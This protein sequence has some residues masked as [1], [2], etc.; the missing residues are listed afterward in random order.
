MKLNNYSYEDYLN[1]EKNAP[2]HNNLNKIYANFSKNSTDFNNLIFYG[3]KGVGKY[4][5][6]LKSI[7]K[8]SPT[9][10]KYERKLIV[11]YNKA[12]YIIKISDIHFEVDM[13]LLGCNSKPLWNEFYLNIVDAISAQPNH[14]G[15]IV[16]KY[17]HE[18]HS[19]LLDCFYSY[20][21]TL[22]DN[23]LI[24]KFI[25]LTEQ[26]SFIPDNIINCCKVIRVPRPSKFNYNKV[27][28]ITSKD[29]LSNISNIKNIPISL[30][31][32]SNQN[33]CDPIIQKIINCKNI[34]YLVMRDNLYDLLI[35]NLDISESIWYIINEL[36]NKNYLSEEKTDKIIIP[37]YR[38]LQYYNNNYRPIYHLESFIYYLINIIHEFE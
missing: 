20:M 8:Y 9:N 32:N 38:F 29:Q 22:N 21:Q 25:F 6:M 34:N 3:P 23:S 11:E 27:C 35:Y 16:C 1:D 15:I 7:V 10:L 17:F 37:M 28:K 36:I 12:N 24:I 31:F 14:L 4:T 18:I 5:Q 26:L 2:F 13:S 30:L 33:L 19:E